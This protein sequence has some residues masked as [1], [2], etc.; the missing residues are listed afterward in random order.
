M[1]NAQKVLEESRK[2]RARI[3]ELVPDY[4]GRWVVFLNNEVKYAFDDEEEA[5][6]TAVNEF[7]VRGGFVVALVTED[8]GAP[9][10]ISAALFFTK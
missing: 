7:G 8:A 9:V 2:F 5:Y 10:P 1:D 3:P 4:N 6:V